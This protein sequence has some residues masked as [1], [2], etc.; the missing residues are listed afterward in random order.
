MLSPRVYLCHSPPRRFVKVG[1]ATDGGARVAVDRQSDL[2]LVD[3]WPAG[4]EVEARAIER[5]VVATWRDRGAVEVPSRVCPD[6]WTATAWLDDIS[7]LEA[8][9]DVER[10]RAEATADS[11]P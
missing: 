4:S 11:I 6:G 9:A 10:A 8:R 5:A 1:V 3:E 2:L 7:L